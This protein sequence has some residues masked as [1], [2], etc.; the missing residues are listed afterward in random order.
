LLTYKG[1][2]MDYRLTHFLKE[3]KVGNG[4]LFTHV[5][6]ITPKGKWFIPGDKMKEFMS[7]YS[8]IISTGGIVGLAEKPEERS[9]VLIDIDLKFDIE[10]GLTRRY[11]PEMVQSVVKIYQ[12]ILKQTIT[13]S[14]PLTYSCVVLE[15]KT[16]R[17]DDPIVKDGFHIMFPF[18]VVEPEFQK[19][20]IRERA[21]IKII[22]AKLFTGMKCINTVEEIVDCIGNKAWLMYGGR[23]DPNLEPYL[24]TK[25]Y[26]SNG[27]P[28]DIPTLFINT[29]GPERTDI[30]V[31]DELDLEREAQDGL[32][33]VEDEEYTGDLNR[34]LPEFLSIR[35]KK[36][37]T[38][39]N[40]SIPVVKIKKEAKQARFA[41]Y[42]SR[43]AEL[44]N[45]EMKQADILVPMLNKQRS[46][47]YLKWME[48]GWCLYNISGGT[49]WGLN[50]W[51]KFSQLSESFQEGKCQELWGSM[52]IRN[53]TIASLRHWAQC[54]NPDSYNAWKKTE[55]S[56]VIRRSFTMTKRDIANVIFKMFE[57]QF[58]CANAEKK[59]WYYFHQHRWHLDDSGMRLLKK[60]SIDVYD[61]Y[62][63]QLNRLTE[64]GRSAGDDE[65]KRIQLQ[66]D[67][68]KVSEIRKKLMDTG[69]KETLLKECRE[70]FHDFHFERKLDTIRHLIGFNNGVYDLENDVFRSGLP[71]DYISK[72]VSYDYHEF[73]GDEEE[74]LAVNDFY[75]KVF[76]NDVLRKYKLRLN[77]SC[78]EGGNNDKIFPVCSGEGG[79]NGKS[80]E[81]E[82]LQHTFGEY[83]ATL[84]TSAVVGEN[85]TASSACNPEFHRLIGVRI[86]SINEPNKTDRL[87]VG[88]I[89]QLSGGDKFYVRGL[90]R[91]GDDTDIL[92]TMFLICNKTPKIPSDEQAMWNR[93]RNI[94]Y[95]ST[96]TDD[97]PDS[98][99]DQYEQKRFLIDRR[100]KS[101]LRRM[102]PANM[103]I[104]LKEYQN[105]RKHGLEEPSEVLQA[106]NQF[107]KNNDTLGLF[108]EENI[109]EEEGASM[110]HTELYQTFKIWYVNSFPGCKG[111]IPSSPEIREELLRRWGKQVKR[112]WQ[113]KAFFEEIVEEEE[114]NGG[115]GGKE[116][117]EKKKELRV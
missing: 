4:E 92:F 41:H 113:N 49:E 54:D 104:L 83:Y 16:P 26:D 25:F 9:P 38:P 7:L 53:Y 51:I 21:I 63:L 32:H 6:M 101:K 97:P 71:E 116:S 94:P 62:G 108:I 103:W 43:G 13:S 52:E 39:V 22:D 66:Q 87:N 109:V 98:E 60:F 76:V 107:R 17:V 102:A 110:S 82:L 42:T 57:G 81:M 59:R 72:S 27:A 46:D 5:S 19:H 65:G 114:V 85:K 84:P 77:A 20:I 91:D 74:V 8:T 47:A 37:Y 28:T 10:M 15:K 61:E 88:L 96:F 70:V 55:L 105:Y 30:S 86:V 44:I 35:G 58:V 75:R 73:E 23:K 68:N 56:H 29:P 93:T 67:E 89:K 36:F 31:L 33:F 106:T 111:S 24:A 79:D 90:Y 2:E 50:L 40:P 117:K 95:E 34:Y 80:M 112:R 3:F 99:E 115:N 45:R 11:T 78:L 14:H 100:L 18:C 12:D 64:E 1:I 48:V 69:F